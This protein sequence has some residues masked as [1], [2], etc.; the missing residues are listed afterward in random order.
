MVQN[1]LFHFCAIEKMIPLAQNKD[2]EMR[3]GKHSDNIVHYRAK[4]KEED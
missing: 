1:T 3:S 2:F 4:E